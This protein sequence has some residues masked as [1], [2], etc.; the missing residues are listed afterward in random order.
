MKYFLKIAEGIPVQP[1]LLSL[2]RQPELWN[3]LTLRTA[4][5]GSPHAAA[6][7]I[8]LRLEALDGSL[9]ARQ[10]LWYEAAKQLPEIRQLVMALAAQVGC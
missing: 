3:A 6:D 8:S 2:Y 9:P 1:A 10:C 7:D 4:T 5:P